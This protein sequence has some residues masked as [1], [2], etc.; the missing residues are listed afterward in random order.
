MNG[1]LNNSTA[2]GPYVDSVVNGGIAIDLDTYKNS[3]NQ[4]SIMYAYD[5]EKNVVELA[6]LHGEENRGDH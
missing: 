1:T 4:T 5:S 3:Q 6:R 2:I